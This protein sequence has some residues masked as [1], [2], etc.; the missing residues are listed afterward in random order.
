MIGGLTYV[1]VRE[2]VEGVVAPTGDIIWSFTDY[3]EA[4]SYASWLDHRTIGCNDGRIYVWNWYGGSGYWNA[5]AFTAL[6]NN[7]YPTP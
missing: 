2:S 4:M 6:D 3:N 5:N 7:N 1:Y